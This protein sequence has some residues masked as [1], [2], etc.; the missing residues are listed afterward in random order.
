M[1]RFKA[2]YKN[3]LWF[4]P[5]DTAAS[6]IQPTAMRASGKG[7]RRSSPQLTDDIST[8]RFPSGLSALNPFRT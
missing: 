2:H 1:R 5:C 8:T 7:I 6:A 3:A 4:L